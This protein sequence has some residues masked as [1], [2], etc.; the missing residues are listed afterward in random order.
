MDVTE[1]LQYEYIGGFN[2]VQVGTELFKA[3]KRLLVS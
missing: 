1:T 3:L 2:A